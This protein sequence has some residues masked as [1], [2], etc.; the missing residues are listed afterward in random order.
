MSVGTVSG[1]DEIFGYDV[2][3]DIIE[4]TVVRDN[5]DNVLFLRG[6]GWMYLYQ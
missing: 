3:K 6:A 1:K 5:A 2:W 4:G